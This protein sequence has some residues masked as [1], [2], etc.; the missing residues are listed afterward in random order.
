M[1]AA[2]KLWLTNGIV[3]IA[4]LH[5]TALLITA[6]L[7]AFNV[8]HLSVLFFSITVNNITQTADIIVVFD[9]WSIRL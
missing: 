5:H 3:I 6:L 8:L 4:V 1:L 7:T 9:T 2:D